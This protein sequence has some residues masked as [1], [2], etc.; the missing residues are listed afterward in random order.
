MIHELF[1]QLGY[2]ASDA[3]QLSQRVWV[4]WHAEACRWDCLKLAE[5]AEHR[6]GI[7][8]EAHWLQRL[9]SAAY[10]SCAAYRGHYQLGSY[11]V[12]IT[13]R[14][15]GRPLSEML[16]QDIEFHP[17]FRNKLYLSLQ[18]LHRLGICHGDIKPA[19]IL[20][21]DDEPVLVDFASAAEPGIAVADLPYRSFSPSYSLPALQRGEG[22]V[23]ILHDWYGY[24]VILSLVNNR[25]LLQPEWSDSE[26]LVKTVNILL[27][28][29]DGL[30]TAARDFLAQQIQ[31]LPDFS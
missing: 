6:Y 1:T 12:L 31:R 19:N 22:A 18:Q 4:A 29:N 14:V 30:T 20:V 27:S 17:E 2:R 24:L 10:S 28:D 3:R 11:E 9:N 26:M 25:T 15:N 7:R 13:S 23:D 5:S 16:R 21:L 8:R